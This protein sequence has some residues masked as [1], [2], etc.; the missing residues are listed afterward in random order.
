MFI[1][2]SETCH[3]DCSESEK[4]DSTEIEDKPVVF[5]A[6]AKEAGAPLKK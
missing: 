3:A 6:G 2:A 1:D 4:G 5:S